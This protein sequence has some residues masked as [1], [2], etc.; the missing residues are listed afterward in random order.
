MWGLTVPKYILS[1]LKTSSTREASISTFGHVF[2]DF[3]IPSFI[4]NPRPCISW[5][6]NWFNDLSRNHKIL[7]NSMILLLTICFA[8]A[9]YSFWIYTSEIFKIHGWIIRYKEH[10][11]M[12]LEKC[13]PL[14]FLPSRS[15]VFLN[16]IPILSFHRFPIIS[17]LYEYNWNS[18]R[19]PSLVKT[20]PVRFEVFPLVPTATRL[21]IHCKCF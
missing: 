4:K 2:N 5:L 15:L 19:I 21:R 13:F 14:I 8:G 16:P 17:M 18:S 7:V 9:T 11:W 3:M 20:L 6:T 1:L 10:A 12:D